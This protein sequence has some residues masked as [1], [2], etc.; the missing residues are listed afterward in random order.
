MI[1][2]NSYKESFRFYL[3]LRPKLQSEQYSNLNQ[4]ISAVRSSMHSVKVWKI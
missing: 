2:W 3:E 1:F 4:L